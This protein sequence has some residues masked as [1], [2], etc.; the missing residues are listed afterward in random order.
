MVD[1]FHHLV[2]GR[3]GSY[4]LFK[5]VRPNGRKLEKN[6]V[7][8]AVVRIFTPGAVEDRTTLIEHPSGNDIPGKKRAGT[9][10]VLP[11]QIER[12]VGK[13]GGH[14]FEFGKKLDP[15]QMLEAFRRG[16]GTH[17]RTYPEGAFPDYD[18]HR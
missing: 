9:A 15:K 18:L 7:E 11:G 1:P 2:V 6:T 12:E 16:W 14:V 4:H 8:P 10:G 3:T 17:G 5:V 13:V